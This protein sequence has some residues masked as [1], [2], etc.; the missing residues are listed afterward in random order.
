VVVDS[1]A[2]VVST[3]EASAVVVSTAEAS[4]AAVSTV[5]VSAVAFVVAVLMAATSV[6][7]FDISDSLMT[8][9]SAASAFRHGGAGA[10]RTDITVT[11]TTRTITMA[12]DT[13]GTLTVTMVAAGT[14]TTVGPVMDIAMAAERGIPEVRGVGDKLGYGSSKSPA[15]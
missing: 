15:C 10:I 4:V 14:V 7:I 5:D 11:T 1:T 8:S 6:A 12:M 13:A 2:A 3:E 9:S